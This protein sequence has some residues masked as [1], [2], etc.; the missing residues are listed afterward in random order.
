[1]RSRTARRCV[2][3]FKA[4]RILSVG[5]AHAPA[6]ERSPDLTSPGMCLTIHYIASPSA[7]GAPSAAPAH[8]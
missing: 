4:K 7:T 3:H 6:G 1:M 8:F 5:A 2:F